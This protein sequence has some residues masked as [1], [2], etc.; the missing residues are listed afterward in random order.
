MS[1]LFAAF[2][3][4]VFFL[5]CNNSGSSGQKCNASNETCLF[6][7]SSLDADY[8]EGEI[9]N[10]ALT[11]DTNFNLVNFSTN[12]QD[13]VHKAAELIKRVVASEEFKEAVINHLY[14]GKKTFVDSGSLSNSQIYQRFLQGAEKLTPALN[15]VMDVELE[16]YYE[17]SSVVGYTQPNTKRIWINTKYFSQYNEAQVAGNI[18]HEWMHKLGF[19]HTSAN[20]SDRANSVPY[21]IGYLMNRFANNYLD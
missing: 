5:S 10:E 8:A 18:T 21:A 12:D 9:P 2:I 16:L 3:L 19:G 11:F 17:S 7:V 14:N 1:K 20:T 15:N 6:N 4:S 13:K